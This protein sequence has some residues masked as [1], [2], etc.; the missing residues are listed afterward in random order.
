MAT[1]ILAF[2]VI[3][4]SLAGLGIGVLLGR[5]ALAGSCGGLACAGC[6]QAGDKACKRNSAPRP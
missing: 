3:L 6:R 5:S 1:F 4:V 2:I